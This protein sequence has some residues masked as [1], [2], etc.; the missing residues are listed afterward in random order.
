M[1]SCGMHKRVSRFSLYLEGRA[2]YTAWRVRRWQSDS[3]RPTNLATQQDDHGITRTVPSH[4]EYSA[5]AR[6]FPDNLSVGFYETGSTS[7]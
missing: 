4:D 1:S 2:R 7:G 5:L 6:V 3:T